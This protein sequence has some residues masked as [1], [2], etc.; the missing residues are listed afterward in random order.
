MTGFRPFLRSVERLES[1]RVVTEVVRARIT[2][3]T[4]IGS[5]SKPGLLHR[6]FRK[7]RPRHYVARIICGPNRIA[8][9]PCSLRA[10]LSLA[11]VHLRP[12]KLIVRSESTVLEAA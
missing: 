6:R 1:K 12:S 11:V 7:E 3:S 9:F 10:C 4:V 2:I 5:L 8:K